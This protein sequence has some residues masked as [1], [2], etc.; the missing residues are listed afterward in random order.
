MIADKLVDQELTMLAHSLTR[1]VLSEA[2]FNAH[3]RYSGRL[4]D[5][6]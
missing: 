2:T 4:A 3:R 6:A 1:N 5:A